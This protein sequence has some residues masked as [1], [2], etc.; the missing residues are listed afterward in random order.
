MLRNQFT[1]PLLSLGSLV[2]FMATPALAEVSEGKLASEFRNVSYSYSASDLVITQ[3]SADLEEFCERYPFNSRCEGLPDTT[4]QTEESESMEEPQAM[5]DAN[6]GW[7]I[8]PEVSTLGLGASVTT[9]I[10]PQFNARLG[11]NAFSVGVDVEETDVTY[12]GDI[13]LLNISGVADYYPFQNSGFKLSAGLVV[14]DNQVDGTLQGNAGQE[15]T[16]GN[17]TFEVGTDFDD[18]DAT[19]EFSNDIAPYLGIGWGNPVR[20]NSRWNFNVN[21]GVMFAG[22]PE[23]SLDPVNV[24]P[25]VQQQVDNAV[26]QEVE[27]LEDEIDGFNIYPVLTL[28]VSYQF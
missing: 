20:P 7:A 22:S 8:T 5:P 6:S 14:N 25:Q 15:V 4:E 26:D 23:V 19:V 28:G 21:L 11:L 13:E 17:D 9:R 12:E 3:R 10:S 27:E 24:D 2:A 1:V 16:I 18:I